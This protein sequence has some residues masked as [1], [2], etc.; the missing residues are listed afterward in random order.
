MSDRGNVVVIGAT[1]RKDLVDSALLRPGRLETHLELGLPATSARR[2]LL[3]ISDV[4]FT[5]EVDLDVLAE[6]TDGLSFADLVGLLRE[7]ALAA[8]RSDSKAPAVDVLHLDAA[9]AHMR[10]R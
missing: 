6:K 1:N 7:A 2:A 9:L 8:L 3:G 5:D 4:P 10:S